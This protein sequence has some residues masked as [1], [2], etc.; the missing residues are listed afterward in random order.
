MQRSHHIQDG[1]KLEFLTQIVSEIENEIKVKISYMASRVFQ[2]ARMVNITPR[3]ECPYAYWIIYEELT[4]GMWLKVLNIAESLRRA[5]DGD[6]ITVPQID[7]YKIWSKL[8]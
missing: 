6:Q 5:G 8:L 2:D 7:M 3:H 4:I 1:L